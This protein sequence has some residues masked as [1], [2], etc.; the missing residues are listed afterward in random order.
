MD[1][2]EIKFSHF[3]E[4]KEKWKYDGFSKGIGEDPR[5]TGK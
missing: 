3:S 2:A 4:V 5:S 1:I